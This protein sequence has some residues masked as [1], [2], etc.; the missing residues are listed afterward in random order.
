MARLSLE[1]NF[2]GDWQTTD[3]VTKGKEY[4][5]LLPQV[6]STASLDAISKGKI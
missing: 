2:T 5:P 6:F 1:K 4:Y 3:S